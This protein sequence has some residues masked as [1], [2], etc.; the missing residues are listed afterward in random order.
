MRVAVYIRVST[1]H[2]VQLQTIEQQLNRLQSYCQTQGWE[3]PTEHLYRDDGYSGAKLSRPAW[4]V[5]V[6][7]LAAPALIVF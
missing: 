7:G 6:M 2:Q 1:P 5:Y 4:I 3:R